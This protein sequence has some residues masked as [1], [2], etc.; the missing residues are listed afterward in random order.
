MVYGV[1]TK[2]MYVSVFGDYVPLFFPVKLPF[3]IFLYQLKVLNIMS[4]TLEK[5]QRGVYSQIVHY[6]KIVPKILYLRPT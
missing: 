3:L 1:H 2:I 6:Y 5:R 4:D